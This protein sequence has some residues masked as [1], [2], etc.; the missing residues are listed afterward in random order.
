MSL[1]SKPIYPTI[2]GIIYIVYSREWGHQFSGCS[3]CKCCSK[4]GPHT[5]PNR[6][7]LAGN[8]WRWR[9]SV[10]NHDTVKKGREWWKTDKSLQKELSG[11]STETDKGSYRQGE[12]GEVGEIVGNVK[13]NK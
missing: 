1:I 3:Q 5:D 7:H 4:H 13:A 6:E 11:E 10:S 9:A 12:T 2:Y 8:G